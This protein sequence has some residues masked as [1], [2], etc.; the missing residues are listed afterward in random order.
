MKIRLFSS[1]WLLL[2]VIEN[3]ALAV[4]AKH[5]ATTSRHAAKAPA[6]RAE[7]AR[8]LRSSRRWARRWRLEIRDPLPSP[9]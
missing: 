7:A 6:W 3:H 9:S 5:L 2:R 1:F 4:S 8:C